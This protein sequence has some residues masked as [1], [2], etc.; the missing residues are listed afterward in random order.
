M[1]SSS[2]FQ[3]LTRAVGHGVDSDLEPIKV[4]ARFLCHL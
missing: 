1:N 4:D 2:D 3:A